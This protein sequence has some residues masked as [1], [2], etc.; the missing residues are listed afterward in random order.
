MAFGLSF[1]KKK[2]S[3]NQTTDS[4]VK[5]NSTTAQTQQT[6]GT[7]QTSTSQSGSTSSNS[8]GLSS[9]DQVNR[10]NQTNSGST[11]TT[12]TTTTLGQG[13]QDQLSG[14]LTGLLGGLG[15]SQK[16]AAASNNLLN[17]DSQQ[18]IDDT[19]RSATVA[20][21]NQ[22]QENNS[23]LGS[24]IGG[25]AGDNTM[26]ALLAQRGSNDLQASLAGVRAQA[27][28]TAAEISRGNVASASAVNAQQAGALSAIGD[29]LK[30]A[31]TTTT[32]QSLEEQ[33]AALVGS[34][35]GNNRTSESNTGTSQQ[36]SSSSQLVNE[37]INALSN[38]NS[39]K[40]GTET[41]K[42]TTKSGGG[43]FSIG[44]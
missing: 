31:T 26:A 21:E 40:T 29:L 34:Q 23:K 36:N 20:G 10:Q 27:T 22:L 11:T 24:A 19:V 33:I 30:G 41:V 7:T 15:D 39:T 38:V 5:E 43:G 28:Q 32:Q 8:Q 13:I 4:T 16:L 14:A 35:V 17:F 2:Q 12:G 9:S 37:L 42:G 44:L 3:Q 6:T 25:T 1:G 18:F